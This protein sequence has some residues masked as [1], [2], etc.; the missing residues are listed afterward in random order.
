M[1]IKMFINDNQSAQHLEWDKTMNK[2]E[3]VHVYPAD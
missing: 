2:L 1:A 3:M